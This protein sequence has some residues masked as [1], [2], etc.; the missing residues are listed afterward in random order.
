MLDRVLFGATVLED[1]IV[2]DN[3]GRSCSLKDVCA[4]SS[5]DSTKVWQSIFV[6]VRAG[7]TDG[8][9]VHG[10]L[11][12]DRVKSFFSSRRRCTRQDD[13]SVEEQVRSPAKVP[14]LG[15]EED[16]A[17]Q[18]ERWTEAPKAAAKLHAALVRRGVAAR[19]AERWI[20]Y[21]SDEGRAAYAYE[22]SRT[23]KV[24]YVATIKEALA[25][26]SALPGAM[27]DV[28]RPKA[29]RMPLSPAPEPAPAPPPEPAPE[30]VPEPVP[31]PAPEPAPEPVPE[32]DLDSDAM[33]IA[34]MD[35]VIEFGYMIAREPL[36]DPVPE[37]DAA[38]AIEPS[39]DDVL[40]EWRLLP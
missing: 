21:V 3:A 18:E 35:A 39:N 19:V 8:G 15:D 36:L 22:H 14:R 10:R 13:D 40:R 12:L 1:D 30:P 38:A 9:Y 28:E 20:A 29:S 17:W 37:P 25:L 27:S 5:T 33:M 4:G 26:S 2:T 23:R 7:T 16:R 24:D 11:S 32:P 31:E 6:A 34:A